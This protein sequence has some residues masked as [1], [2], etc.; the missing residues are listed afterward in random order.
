M[1][2]LCSK[3]AKHDACEHPDPKMRKWVRHFC[4]LSCGACGML[5][6]IFS[7]HCFFAGLGTHY[8]TIGVTFVI[9]SCSSTLFVICIAKI[10]FQKLDLSFIAKAEAITSGSLQ[11]LDGCFSFCQPCLINALGV[12]STAFCENFLRGQL[13]FCFCRYNPHYGISTSRHHGNE[14]QVFPWLTYM[15]NISVFSGFF[16]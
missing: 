13:V 2:S 8:P 16:F 14:M 1:H 6:P 10:M 9:C 3:L 11:R 15:I 12:C 7:H 4:P 5:K